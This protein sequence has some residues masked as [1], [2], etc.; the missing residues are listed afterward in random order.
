M[1]KSVGNQNAFPMVCSIE[2]DPSELHG[3]RIHWV[4]STDGMS[5]RHWLIGQALQGL[6]ART[7]QQQGPDVDDLAKWAI[8][9][10]D[11]VIAL[12]DKEGAK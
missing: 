8:Q 7:F 5:L 4:K 12:L 10:A 9:Q 2:A 3:D 11:A 1:N 6:C